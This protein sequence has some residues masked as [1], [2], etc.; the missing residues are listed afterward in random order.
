MIKFY[1]VNDSICVTVVQWSRSGVPLLFFFACP[2]LCSPKSC[3]QQRGGLEKKAKME[4]E[5]G[6]FT[7]GP[8]LQ[9]LNIKFGQ[10]FA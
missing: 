9:E 6:F 3:G 8:P 2:M 10:K 1:N 4:I 5:T 7:T